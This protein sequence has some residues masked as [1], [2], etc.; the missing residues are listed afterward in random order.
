MAPDPFA[1][2]DRVERAAVAASVAG[3]LPPRK[4][5]AR[6]RGK[7]PIPAALPRAGPPGL[8]RYRVRHAIRVRIR[9]QVLRNRQDPRLGKRRAGAQ[10]QLR[11]RTKG[12]RRSQG[13]AFGVF[14]AALPR[15]LLYFLYRWETCVRKATVLGMPGVGGL[16][17]WIS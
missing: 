4:K 2:L 14:P 3:R 11:R 17:Y 8:K 7:H 15:F 10:R 13:A 16:G 12:A 5:Y 1:R 9:C 6:V